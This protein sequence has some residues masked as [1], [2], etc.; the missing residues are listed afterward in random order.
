MRPW[1]AKGPAMP[2]SISST[3]TYLVHFLH[4]YVQQLERHGR[5]QLWLQ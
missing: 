2:L 3:A 1:V 4:F 5:W